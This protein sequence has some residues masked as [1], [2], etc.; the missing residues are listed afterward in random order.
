LN[1]R[2]RPDVAIESAA[3]EYTVVLQ[4]DE[5]I[6]FPL[7]SFAAHLEGGV[8]RGMKAV[9]IRLET[10]TSSKVPLS[11]RWTGGRKVSASFFWAGGS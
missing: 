11:R 5:Q 8:R 3:L 10:P 1:G 7:F 4:V 6:L 9:K 2:I